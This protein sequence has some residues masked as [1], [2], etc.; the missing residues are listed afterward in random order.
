MGFCGFC[1][2]NMFIFEHTNYMSIFLESFC[3]ILRGNANATHI[4]MGMSFSD[5]VL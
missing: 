4:S 1:A 3:L 5:H 2:M